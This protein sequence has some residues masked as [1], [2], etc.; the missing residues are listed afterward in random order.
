M[1]TIAYLAVSVDGYIA[2]KDDGLDWL[3]ELP[4]PEQ[5]DFGYAD[6][7]SG[8][9][10]LLMGSRTFQVVLDFGVW[11][12]EKPVFV[13]SRQMTEIPAGYEERISLVQ[14][15]MAEILHSIREQGYGNIYVD[16]GILIRSCLREGLLDEMILTRI[17]IVLGDGVPL[18]VPS[19]QSIDL[20]HV[21]TQIHGVGLVQSH[22]R[23]K[24]L[25]G[26]V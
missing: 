11:H 9:D 16:G 15:E 26:S 8:I 2:A 20:E 6:F 5:S 19:E 18:F 7:M 12:Y 10:A 17:P 21:S 25:D 1:K 23:I 13:A 24:K 22:Y 14:G 4:N 3:N